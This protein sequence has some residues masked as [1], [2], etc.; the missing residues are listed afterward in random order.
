MDQE[1]AELAG[2]VLEGKYRI[3]RLVG[4]GGMGSV[5]EAVH[6]GIDRRCAVKVLRT[7]VGARPELVTRFAREA[8]IAGSLGHP[9]IVDITDTGTTPSGAP[10]LVMELL[11]GRSLAQTLDAEGPFGVELAVEI[12]ATVLE[13]LAVVHSRGIVHRDLKPANI[14]LA[15]V[16]RPRRREKVVKILDFGISKPICAE[17][18]AESFT[19]PGTLLGTPAY[20]A[21]EQSLRGQ[22]DARTDI[23]SVGVVLYEMLTGQTP[24]PGATLLEQVVAILMAGP[25]PPSAH[26]LGVPP[27][28]DAVVLKAIAREREDRYGSADELLEALAPFAPSLGARRSSRPP[29]EVATSPGRGRRADA[30]ESDA[31]ASDGGGESL[32][33]RPRRWAPLIVASV[34][35]AIGAVAAGLLWP[36]SG[37]EPA[38]AEASEATGSEATPPGPSEGTEDERPAPDRLVDPPRASAAPTTPHREGA[39]PPE[40]GAFRAVEPAPGRG[41]L[42]RPR[43]VGG[44]RGGTPAAEPRSSRG[45]RPLEIDREPPA[46]LRPPEAAGEGEVGPARTDGDDGWEP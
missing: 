6:T 15:E 1:R 18:G 13:A 38:R 5:Y 22:A 45:R 31:G 26:R 30:P 11:E 14:F 7:E 28:L 3:E 33:Y 20:M 40:G 43:H 24:F 21:P 32:V 23:Y 10:Y 4:R 16:E 39:P 17:P 25:L 19:E 9:N 34:L 36:R 44:G 41:R 29:P 12:V 8:R 46:R 35:L 37:D 42:A 27:E 2:S